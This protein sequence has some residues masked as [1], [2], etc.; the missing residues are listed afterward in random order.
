MTPEQ[1]QAIK[2]RRATA[3][4]ETV[5]HA[6]RVL[7]DIDT[8]LAE[9]ERQAEALAAVPVDSIRYCWQPNRD[10]DDWALHSDN[11]ENWLRE[12]TTL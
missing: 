6:G 9:V 10:D 4:G 8:L 12:T 3:E 7:A 5:L 1:L 11:V 2:V